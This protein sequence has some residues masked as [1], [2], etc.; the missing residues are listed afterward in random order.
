MLVAIK[1]TSDEQNVMFKSSVFFFFFFAR[2]NFQVES[3]GEKRNKQ[4]KKTGAKSRGGYTS[5]F[6]AGVCRP[7]PQILTQFQTKIFHFPHP[8]SDLAPVVQRPDNFIRWIR[9]YPGSKIYLHVKR[10]PRFLYTPKLSC[11]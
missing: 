10:C 8:F 1:T 11:G 6:L 9:H 2:I 3:K 5:K 7:V 4:G